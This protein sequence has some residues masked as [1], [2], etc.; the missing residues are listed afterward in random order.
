MTTPEPLRFSAADANHA[1][2]KWGANCGPGAL[3]AALG[4]TLNQVRNHLIGFYAKGYTNPTMMWDALH[5]L[6]AEFHINAKKPVLWPRCGLAR[7]QW[8]GPWTKPGVPP[9]VAY[10]HT[11][12]VA[13]DSRDASNVGIFDINAMSSGGW[14]SLKDWS[15][16]LV[17]WLL[18]ETEPKASGLWHLTHAAQIDRR[19]DIA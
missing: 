6:G 11:H 16:S 18:K 13:V 2:E 12:W 4:L 8:E 9:R 15:E 7:I 1:Y 5:S 10:R 19:G 14:I 17:P 3:A